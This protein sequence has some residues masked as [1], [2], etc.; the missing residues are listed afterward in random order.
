MNKPSFLRQYALTEGRTVSTG[1]DLPL[2]ALITTTEACG[3]HLIEGTLTSERAEIAILAATPLSVAE[4]SAK[5]HVHLGI[6]RVLVSDMADQGLLAVSTAD[7]DEIGPDLHTLE[8]L[9][10][11]LQAL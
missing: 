4:V 6:A 2:D 5:L 7:F 1:R 9:L 3:A 10:D 8:R 11:D